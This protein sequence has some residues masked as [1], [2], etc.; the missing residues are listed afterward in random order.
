MSLG[1]AVACLAGYL[2]L[3]RQLSVV[4]AVAIALVIGAVRT[5][6]VL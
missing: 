6:A 2:L 5:A 4:E 1:P 3:G